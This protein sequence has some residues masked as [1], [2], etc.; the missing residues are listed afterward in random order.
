[1]ESF[2]EMLQKDMNEARKFSEKN[3]GKKAMKVINAMEEFDNMWSDYQETELHDEKGLRNE[4][5]LIKSF[6]EFQQLMYGV[7]EQ[8][9]AV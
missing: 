8:F 1:M 6:K 5:Q 7:A 4:K 2:K 9:R 3:F